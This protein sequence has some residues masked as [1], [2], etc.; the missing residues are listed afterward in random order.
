MPLQFRCL[1][2][3]LIITVCAWKRILWTTIQCRFCNKKR[4]FCVYT[5]HRTYSTFDCFSSVYY[6][7]PHSTAL[8]INNSQLMECGFI[9]GKDIRVRGGNFIV[10][11]S[12]F[13]QKLMD[14]KS[15]MFPQNSVSYW[16]WHFQSLTFSSSR[17]LNCVVVIQKPLDRHLIK[18]YQLI[19]F[20]RS[21]FKISN[22]II[23]NCVFY[24]LFV[25]CTI[26][27]VSLEDSWKYVVYVI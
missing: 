14:C 16:V 12:E 26:R 3:G 4:T 24:F 19:F 17:P 10:L 8:S 27:N 1:T 6:F 25:G 20:F 22:A 9:T 15:P 13:M 23:Y 5:L 2:P 18:L 7:S 21:F 11:A